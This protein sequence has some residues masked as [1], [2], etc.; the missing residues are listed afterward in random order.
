MGE[1]SDKPK[2]AIDNCGKYYVEA[3]TFFMTGDHL[4]YLMHFLNSSLSK[5]FFAQL[6]TTTGVGTTRWKKFKLELFPIPKPNKL[7]LD[8]INILSSNNYNIDDIDDIIFSIYSFTPE[9]IDA[10]LEFDNK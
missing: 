10:I 8:I 9:E 6:G 7:E 4:I 2:F 3:T 1:I 5:Y